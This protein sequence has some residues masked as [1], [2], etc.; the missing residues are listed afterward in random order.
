MLVHYG[1]KISS[2]DSTF[3]L[4]K[5]SFGKNSKKNAYKIMNDH[6]KKYH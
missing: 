6:K 3:T 4:A 1:K 5:N 2:A